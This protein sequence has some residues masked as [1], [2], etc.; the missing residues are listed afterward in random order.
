MVGDRQ[1]Q[2]GLPVLCLDA[3]FP[4]TLQKYF[5]GRVMIGLDR[6]EV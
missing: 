3:S 1:S 2:G 6:G 5:E 4:A